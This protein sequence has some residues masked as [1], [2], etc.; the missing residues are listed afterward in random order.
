MQRILES[1]LDVAN[2]SKASPASVEMDSVPVSTAGFAVCK[3]LQHGM[4]SAQSR[5]WL[6]AVT[7]EHEREGIDRR[8]ELLHQELADRAIVDSCAAK[9]TKRVM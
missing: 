2:A 9:L 1:Q 6:A 3:T 4:P 5:R 7:E 8:A